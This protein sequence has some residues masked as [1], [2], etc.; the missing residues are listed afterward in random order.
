MCTSK[1]SNSE[2]PK[3]TKFLSPWIAYPLALFVW[4]VLP[5]VVSQ[6]TPHYGWVA[7]RPS[8]WNLLGLIPVA[9]GTI[10]LLWGVAA[11]SAQSSQGIEWERDKSYLLRRGMYAYS[12][13]PM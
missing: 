3:K 13:N 7:G 11:H 8:P 1:I 10:G 4:W 9:I 12:R 2:Q 6:L 5:W